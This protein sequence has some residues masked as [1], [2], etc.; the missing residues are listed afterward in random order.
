MKELPIIYS[1]PMVQ[2]ILEGRKTQTRRIIKP[3][4]HPYGTEIIDS[5]RTWYKG[6]GRWHNRLIAQENPLRYEIASLHDCPYGEIGDLLWVR[7]TWSHCN[8]PLRPF[9]YKAS[10][11]KQSGLTVKWSPSIHM[12]KEAARIW[13]KVVDVRVDRLNHISEKDAI[14]EGVKSRYSF[15]FSETRYEDYSNR[16]SEWRDPVLS[17]YTLWESIHGEGS[18]EKNP[19]VW[20]IESEVVSK[21]GRPQ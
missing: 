20:V 11:E 15:L 2:A 9:M 21:T 12:P 10:I 6:K 17:F 19:W 1:M 5:G 3:E 8:H 7:E 16:D 14:A 18:W 4:P 13:L